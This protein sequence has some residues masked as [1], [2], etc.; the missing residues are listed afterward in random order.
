M[1]SVS[2]AIILGIV[3]GLTEF[4]PVSSSAHLALIPRFLGWEDPGLAFDVAL[5]LGT[6]AGVLGYFW[7]DLWKIVT[8]AVPSS[9]RAAS[10]PPL[11]LYLIVGTIPGALAGLVL[12]PKVETLFRSPILIAWTLIVMG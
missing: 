12:E 10:G 2:Q 7:K 6:L 5:H 1:F 9:G 4:L 8:D 11:L 3:Q